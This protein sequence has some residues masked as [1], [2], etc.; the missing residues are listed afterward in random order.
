MLRRLHG[1]PADGRSWS[2]APALVFCT[3]Q[4]SLGSSCLPFPPES[5]LTSPVRDMPGIRLLSTAVTFRL[6][7]SC[8]VSS[9][10]QAVEECCCN[11]IDAG[12]QI[13][14]EVASGSCFRTTLSADCRWLQVPLALRCTSMPSSWP[15]VWKMTAMASP[16]MTSA[17]WV[18]P[19]L[20]KAALSAAAAA[21]ISH[22]RI[23]R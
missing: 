19:C 5:A 2:A 13:C 1:L 23:Q 14:L 3:W 7:S 9:L 16:L 4:S 20:L 12:Q 18:L 6:R 11:S 22:A 8:I 21:G 10:A 15:S 17:S